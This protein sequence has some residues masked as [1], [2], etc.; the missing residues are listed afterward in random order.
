MLNPEPGQTVSLFDSRAFFAK[1]LAYGVKN[2][3]LQPQKL[4][5]MCLEAPKGMVQIA[6]YFGT[7]YLRP[8]LERAKDRMVNLISLHLEYSTH[9]DLRQA[10]ELLRDNSLLSRSKAGS[11]ML[12]ALIAMPQNSHFG[13]H[14]AGGFQDEHIPLLARWTLRSLPDYQSEL[15][16]REQVSQLVYAALWM[17]AQLGLD[18]ADL[19]TANAD[20]EGV[21]RTALLAL[22]AKRAEM[23]DWIGF[24]KL[25]AQVCKKAAGGVITSTLPL[26]KKVPAELLATIEQVRQS[27][28]ADL[29]KIAESTLPARKLFGQ[30]PAFMGRYF[31][32][33]DALAEVEHFER[34]LSAAWDKAT[35]GHSDDGSLLT[36]FLCLATGTSAK[37]LLTEKAATTL[38]RKVRKL[39]LNAALA[40]TF[41]ED[42]APDAHRDDYLNLW[43]DFLEDSLPTLTSD[44][45]YELND[46][47][48]LLRRECNVKA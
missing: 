6:R 1:A 48:S 45:D 33:E 35:S 39:G 8:E 16:K 47:L 29:P 23:P 9:G 25:V 18:E 30:T 41:I 42:H 17:A 38:L 32:L 20:A 4:E 7:E 31:W 13:M 27:V 46:A 44:R 22:A 24:E 43:Q 37:T 36:L 28:L 12:K 11:D 19:Q 21:I 3:I 15:T 10:A 2:G 5:S 26:P 34:N 40:T 14:E